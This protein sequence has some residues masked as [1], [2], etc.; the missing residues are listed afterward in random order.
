MKEVEEKAKKY[1]SYEETLNLEKT[2]FENVDNV[3]LYLNLRLDMWY[4]YFYFF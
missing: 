3:R 4:E 1:S 2:N